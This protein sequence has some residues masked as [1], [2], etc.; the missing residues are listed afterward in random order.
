MSSHSPIIRPL[1]PDDS[2][3]EITDLLHRAYKQL[4][5][6]GLRYFA[7]HQTV[8]QTHNRFQHAAGSYVALLEGQIVGTIKWNRGSPTDTDAPQLYQDPQVAIFGQ[9]GVEPALQR[10]GIGRQLFDHLVAEARQAGCT[11]LALDTAESAT[12]LTRW[13]ERLGFQFVHHVRWKQ[14]NYQSVVMSRLLW[15]E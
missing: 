1:H 9:F 5:D 7:T 14:T 6:M 2:L 10:R 8:E 13:Y 3:E 12:H 11:T 4:A 15:P